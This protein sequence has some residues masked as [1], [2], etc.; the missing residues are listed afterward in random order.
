MTVETDPADYTP[1]PF[2]LQISGFIVARRARCLELDPEARSALQETS[3]RF[4]LAADTML[5]VNPLPSTFNPGSSDEPG[6]QEIVFED[7]GLVCIRQVV[8]RPRIGTAIQHFRFVPEHRAADSRMAVPAREANSAA[9]MEIIRHPDRRWEVSH[10]DVV[11]EFRG[12]GLAALLYFQLW[13][14]MGPM[15][16]PS[17]WLSED[18]YRYHGH[19]SPRHL[20]WYRKDPGGSG[21][22]VSPKQMVH[23]R[24]ALNIAENGWG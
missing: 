11:P 8:E 18:A 14:L 4:F 6:P 19:T 20:E 5:E 3:A 15:M 2:D 24:F 23:M 21:L 13:Q 9:V 7:D 1:T 22:W 16:R 10:I 12:Q 17:G